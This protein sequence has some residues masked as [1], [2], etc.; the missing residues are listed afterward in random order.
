MQSSS[1][2][3]QYFLVLLEKKQWLMANIPEPWSSRLT[4][5][6]MFR[7]LT[8]HEQDSGVVVLNK[9]EVFG[10][11]LSACR[12]VSKT[13]RDIFYKEF[14]V[15]K[16]AWWIGF[17]L[18]SESYTDL[19]NHSG[20]GVYGESRDTN[21]KLECCGHM[22]SFD[23][24]GDPLWVNG[25]FRGDSTYKKFT[26][27]SYDGD[28]DFVPRCTPT[29]V[30]ALNAQQRETIDAISKLY[31]PDPLVNNHHLDPNIYKYLNLKKKH[32]EKIKKLK[33]KRNVK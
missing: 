27:Y 25:A 1:E 8:E 18:I 20:S 5:S 21:G 12:L 9:K 19:S 15:E 3:D 10:G 28:W 17:E 24:R 4:S 14:Y 31:L 29:K 26:H 22:A 13:V 33:K 30:T 6:R 32:K 2:I 16:E 7:S 23:R 11:I